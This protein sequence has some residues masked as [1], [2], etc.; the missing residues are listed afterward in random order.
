MEYQILPN[1]EA[2]VPHFCSLKSSARD[3]GVVVAFA[4]TFVLVFVFADTLALRRSFPPLP[5]RH[6]EKLVV[7]L[8]RQ[9]ASDVAV[10]E[11]AHRPGG[12]R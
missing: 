8:A 12:G 7:W 9:H 5:A 11:R 3:A 4:L 10:G 1:C 2:P 6:L